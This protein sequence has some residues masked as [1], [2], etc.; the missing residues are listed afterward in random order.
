MPGSQ[1]HVRYYVVSAVVV[2]HPYLSPVISRQII[3]GCYY[4]RIQPTQ[5]VAYIS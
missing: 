4:Q 2:G 3:V 1:R 5:V